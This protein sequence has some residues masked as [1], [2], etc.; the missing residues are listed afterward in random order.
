MEDANLSAKMEG[1]QPIPAVAAIILEEGKL[2]LIRRGAEPNKDKW[3]IPGG[4]VQW[5]EPLKEAIKREVRE[6]T[7]LDVEVGKIAGVFDL[8]VRD[9]AGNVAYHYVIIDFF[10]KPVGGKLIPGDDAVQVRWVPIEQ[11]GE[12][13]LSTFLMSRLKQM[14]VL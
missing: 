12:Y 10:A 6:E 5:G 1:K 7:G 2:L 11:V 9:E 13:E 14:K 3:S 8:I 4:S